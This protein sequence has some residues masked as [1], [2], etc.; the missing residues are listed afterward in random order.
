M[1]PGQE[2]TICTLECTVDKCQTGLDIP[3]KAKMKV[4]HYI[5]KTANHSL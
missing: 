2:C 5:V 3:S 4:T 1:L